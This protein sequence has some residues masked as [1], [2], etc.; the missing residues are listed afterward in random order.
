MI[1]RVGD[2]GERE[3]A[4]R[5]SGIIWRGLPDDRPLMGRA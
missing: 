2:A 1:Q 5:S 3:R 4:M